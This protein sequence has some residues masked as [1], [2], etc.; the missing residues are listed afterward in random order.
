MGAS[1]LLME[2]EESV[3]PLTIT[4]LSSYLPNNYTKFHPMVSK[5]GGIDLKDKER[6]QT[7][8]GNKPILLLFR[9][10]R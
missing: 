1:I 8:E 7:F 2:G 10:L 3:S 5:G 9:S 6:Q 4:Y